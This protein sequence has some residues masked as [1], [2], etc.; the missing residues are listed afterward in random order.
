MQRH[1]DASM[2]PSHQMNTSF[3]LSKQKKKGVKKYTGPRLVILSS[4]SLLSGRGVESA[5]RGMYAGILSS[6]RLFGRERATKGSA[7][8]TS[9][10]PISEPSSCC[11]KRLPSCLTWRAASVT[12]VGTELADRWKLCVGLS[13]EYSGFWIMT[14]GEPV[15]AD[16]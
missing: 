11:A 15:T 16:S 4:T 8:C 2:Q 3:A 1:E 10:D 13:S 12:S 7:A 6:G 5:T 9:V 14:G